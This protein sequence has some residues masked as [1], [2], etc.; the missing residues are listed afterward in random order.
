MSLDAQPNT[1]TH[2]ASHG[3]PM[4]GSPQKSFIDRRQNSQQA[5]S[6]NERRQFGNSHRDLS[7]EGRELAVAIDRYKIDHHRRYLTCDEMLGVLRELGYH[8]N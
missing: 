5:N 2:S 6:Q 7:D 1:P 4:F 3:L 8:K